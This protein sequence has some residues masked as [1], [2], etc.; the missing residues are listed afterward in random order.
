[1]ALLDMG[2]PSFL[3]SVIAFL[4]LLP[5]LFRLAKSIAV[6]IAGLCMLSLFYLHFM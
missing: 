6:T 1:M 5:L 3:L 2:N 4:F